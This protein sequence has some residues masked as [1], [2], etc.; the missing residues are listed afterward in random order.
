MSL[1]HGPKAPTWMVH[2]IVIGLVGIGVIRV[3]E[4]FLIT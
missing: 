1:K 3:D 4:Y 2:I